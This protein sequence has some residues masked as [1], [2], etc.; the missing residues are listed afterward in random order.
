M[1]QHGEQMNQEMQEPSLDISI[2]MKEQTTAMFD[3]FG[4]HDLGCLAGKHSLGLFILRCGLYINNMS[5]VQILQNG[6][7][8]IHAN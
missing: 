5:T 7:I 4:R 8:Q 1:R 3:Q 2:Q 6:S